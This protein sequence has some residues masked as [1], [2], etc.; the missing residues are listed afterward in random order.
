MELISKEI[1]EVEGERYWLET[2]NTGATVQYPWVD[3]NAPAL[4]P[5]PEPES[6]PT[7]TEMIMDAIATVYEAVLENKE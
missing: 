3:P 1:I 4:E 5:T 6:E 2:Y 7:D